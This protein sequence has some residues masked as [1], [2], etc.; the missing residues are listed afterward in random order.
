MSAAIPFPFA[1]VFGIARGR[2]VGVGGTSIGAARLPTDSIGTFD[3]TL[4]N[5]VVNSAIRVEIAGSGALVEYR[6][7]D[8]TT[9]VF[10]VPAYTTGNSNNSLR[11]KVRKGSGAPLYKPYETQATAIIGAQSIFIAQIAD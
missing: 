9:E 10:N 3:T 5:L 11:I 8:A 1:T 2:I 6:I 7:A 4:T